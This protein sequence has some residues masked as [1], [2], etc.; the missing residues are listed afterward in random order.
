M[1]IIQKKIRTG[2]VRIIY[3]RGYGQLTSEGYQGNL[4]EGE[5]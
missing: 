4:H 2:K 1:K 5:F 3:T